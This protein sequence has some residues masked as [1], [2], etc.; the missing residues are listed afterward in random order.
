MDFAISGVHLNP[1]Y[2]AAVGF[3]VGIL[4]GFF[5]VGGSFIAGPALF[6]VGVPMNFVVGTDLA[7]IVGKSIVAAKKHRALGNVDFKL[8]LIMVIGTIAGV[9]AGAQIV[10]H[11]KR[12]AKADVV[13][14]S[15]F[16]VVLVAMSVFIGWESWQTLQM[17]GGG[18][19]SGGR[20][21]AGGVKRD[22]SVIAFVARAVHAFHLPP[23]ISLPASGI[24]RVSLWP[25]LAVAV[26][27]GLFSGFL[28]GGAGY[29]RMPTL[30]Y[31]LG[32]PTH[33]AVGTDL[34]EVVISAG[35]GTFT[36]ALKGN[37]DILIAL[38][39]H[40]GA[41]I[42]AQIGATLTEKFHGVGIRLA[43]A[44]LP[45]LGAGLIIYTLLSRHLI[46]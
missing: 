35:Y 37:V 46:H 20:R 40:T 16:V 17:R 31:L 12:L 34:F 26:V 15:A 29:I 24:A 18:A 25:I 30:V 9:E 39:M 7:H 13:I 14:A 23:M 22:A 44:P 10:Q 4:G 11:L 33:L 28:G 38:V 8:G 2:L 21:R 19:K 6:A 3:V 42:G 45:L 36:H 5:G 27:G 41:A 1:L 32:V 43:F